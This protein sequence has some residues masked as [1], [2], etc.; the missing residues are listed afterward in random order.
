MR[1]NSSIQLHFLPRTDGR[2]DTLFEYNPGVFHDLIKNREWVIGAL[3]EEAGKYLGW[4][5]FA[6]NDPLLVEQPGD[7]QPLIIGVYVV[8]EK[9]RQGLGRK[10]IS[11]IFSNYGRIDHM[12]ESKQEEF[13]KAMQLPCL[14]DPNSWNLIKQYSHVQFAVIPQEVESEEDELSFA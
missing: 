11:H 14:Y 1:I 13:V 9:R 5:C 4:A 3:A 7:V 12:P 6:I 8:P 2:L 10:L